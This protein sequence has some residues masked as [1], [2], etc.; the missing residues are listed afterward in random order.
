MR[1]IVGGVTL[2]GG[3][4]C[5]WLLAIAGMGVAAA[6]SWCDCAGADKGA[7][8]PVWAMTA[9]DSAVASIGRL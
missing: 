7:A 2:S 4:T 1:T 8:P 5:G 3:A 6:S 9:G